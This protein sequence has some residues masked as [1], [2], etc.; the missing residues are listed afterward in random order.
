MPDGRTVPPRGSRRLDRPTEGGSRDG[1]LVSRPDRY[2]HPSPDLESV[3]GLIQAR[4]DGVISR[5]AL[6]RRAAALGIAAPVVGVMLHATSDM[7]YGAPS[8]GRSGTLQSPR[9]RAPA[10][11]PAEAADR[12]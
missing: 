9:R 2:A 11:V 7:A 4:I 1:R 12:P 8:S 6:I 3:N 10:T 5:R